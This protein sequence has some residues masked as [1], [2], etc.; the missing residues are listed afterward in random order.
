[1]SK[2]LEKPL[3]TGAIVLLC[4]GLY[5]GLTFGLGRNLTAE[6]LALFGYTMDPVAIW[7]GD[8]LPL[9]SGAFLHPNLL[10]LL[11]NLIWIWGLG[12]RIEL[13]W[14]RQ[15]LVLV[16]LGSAVV[17]SAAQLAT[18]N[19]WP[20]MGA[21]GV[22][23]AMFGVMWGARHHVREFRHFMAPQ[24]VRFVI[25]W[26]L[27]CVVITHFGLLNIGNA[28]HV[29]GL[30]F[31][32]AAAKV[33]FGGR[34]RPVA[35]VGLAACAVLVVL[36]LSWLPWV[37]KWTYYRAGELVQA[38]Q[39]EQAQR[40]FKP[41]VSQDDPIMLNDWAWRMATSPY[42]PLRNAERAIRMARRACALTRWSDPNIIDTLAA[43]YAQDEQW[44]KAEQTQLLALGMLQEVDFR[45]LQQRTF[46][47]S[48][49]QQ[50]LGMIRRK[51]KIR[52]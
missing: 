8:Y 6:K 38:G 40:L 46:V 37:E 30:L 7:R 36:S 44:D 13:A 15:P 2:I 22:V 14:G 48:I 1:M 23:C 21:S 43:A 17:A 20:A 35:I 31:G 27:L 4:V 11:F 29:A 33:A 16:V 42:E 24:I 28:A 41:R 50:H 39:V 26:L 52:E 47:E 3:L 12:A 5:V 51:T 10:H 32:L 18:P 19:G 49:L 45:T 34:W 25:G 9:L